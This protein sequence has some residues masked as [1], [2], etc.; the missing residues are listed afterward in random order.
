MTREDAGRATR[1]DRC[2]VL[3]F[4]FPRGRALSLSFF[5]KARRALS[6]VYDSIVFSSSLTFQ[7]VV[8]AGLCIFI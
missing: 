7:V 5:L 3:W 6:F 1:L 8:L 2:L 4:L